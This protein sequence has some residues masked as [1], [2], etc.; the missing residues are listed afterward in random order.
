MEHRLVTNQ[1]GPVEKVVYQCVSQPVQRW[2]ISR[3][4]LNLIRRQGTSSN[5][6]WLGSVIYQITVCKF[7]FIVICIIKEMLCQTKHTLRSTVVHFVFDFTLYNSY[8]CQNVFRAGRQ[9]PLFYL[10]RYAKTKLPSCVSPSKL[11]N[12]KLIIFL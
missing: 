4:L 1:L 7:A 8:A 2:F 10:S 6:I 5:Q 12:I 11:L 9:I 3:N